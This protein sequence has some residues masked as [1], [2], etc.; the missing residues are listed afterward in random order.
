MILMDG[1]KLS[2]K[3]IEN[4]KNRVVKLNNPP[5]LVMI[6]IGNNPV[7]SIYLKHKQ[8]AC[9]KI[10]IKS[11]KIILSLTTS[12][13]T[14]KE[15]IETLNKDDDVDGII[16]QFPLPQGMS[17]QKVALLVDSHKDADGIH[18]FN[19]GINVT[20]TSYDSPKPCTPKG[21]M[22]L[23]KEYKIQ[24]QGKHAVV[25]G[26]SNIAGRPLANM[27][28]NAHATV[29]QIHSKTKSDV[30]KNLLKKADIIVT[31]TGYKDI[32]YPT[33]VKKGVVIVDI[34]IFKENNKIRGDIKYQ[35][36]NHKA[37]YITP[38]PGGVGPMTV[39]MLMDNV[40]TIKENKKQ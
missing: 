9:Q 27:L 4:F 20:N 31:A 22:E 25:I 37:S 19:Q 24:I 14:L 28:I 15:K 29:S 33:D 18:P 21:V 23:L 2:N 35:T 11:T 13:D 16:V 6:Q 32:F 5:H 39:A 26:R 12:F 10:G 38:V 7:S 30:K 17:K 34:G 40:I 3:K 36:F 1:K 8:I